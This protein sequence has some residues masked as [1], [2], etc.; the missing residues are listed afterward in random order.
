MRLAAT[1]TSDVGLRRT[2]NED[3]FLLV[4]EAGLFAVA[5]G[6]GGHASGEVASRL[7]VESLR[8][9]FGRLEGAPAERLRGAVLEANRIVHARSAADPHLSGMGTTLVSAWFPERGPIA[10]AHVGDSRAYVFRD[11]RLVRLT[12]D[13]TL[14]AEFIREASPTDEEIAAYPNKHVVVR[15]LGMRDTVEVDVSL[16][17]VREGDLLLLCCDGLFGMVSDDQMAG[18]LRQEGADILR[19]NQVLVD[20]AIDAGGVDN[21][22]AVLVEVVERP[23]G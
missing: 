23:A 13:H 17:D 11:G 22:T 14:L 21:V 2:R 16:V 7:A 10:V 15:A 8:D 6:L 20:A 4:P 12:E 9:A 19:A 1:G 3:A 5:D 18:I